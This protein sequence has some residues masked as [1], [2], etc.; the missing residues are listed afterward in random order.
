MAWAL[1]GLSLVTYSAPLA[2]ASGGTPPPPDLAAEPSKPIERPGVITDLSPQ[3]RVTLAEPIRVR[4]DR[5]VDRRSVEAEFVVDPPTPGVFEWTSPRTFAWHPSRWHEGT[6]HTVRIAG[7]GARGTP[8]LDTAWSFRAHVPPPPPL[9]PGDGAHVVLTFDDSPHEPGQAERLLDDL[10][11]MRVR[12][13]LFPENRWAKLHPEWV[14]RALA[15]GHRVCNH[16]LNHR[17]LTDLDDRGVR[18]EIENGAGHGR[19]DLLRPPFGATDARVEAIASELGYRL[20]LWDVDSHDWEGLPAD[21]IAHG[22]LR[23]VGPG[24]VVLFHIHAEATFDALPK[25]VRT[26]RR[27]G[28][29]LSPDDTGGAPES[30]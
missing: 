8:L 14:E 20:M 10:R 22:V 17:D 11:F 2:S 28:Y 16:T 18:Y 15:D 9:A 5:A 27:A 6:I 3:G 4:F 23:R 21:D 12:A 24:G 25:I 19:C 30:G 13:I 1:V 7:D 29:V 26:L